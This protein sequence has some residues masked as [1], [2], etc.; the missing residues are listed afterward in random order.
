MRTR[1]CFWLLILL[2]FVVYGPA[3][4]MDYGFRD[5]YAYLREAREE[6]G[7]LVFFN[8]SQGRPLYGALIETSFGRLDSASDLEWFRLLT[9]VELALLAIVL[10]RHFEFSGWPQVDAAFA[11]FAIVML[12][13]AQVAAGWAIGWPWVASL[14]LSVAGFMAVDT[15][16]EKGGLKRTMG[17]VGGIFIYA[18]SAL[19]YQSNV[20]FAVVPL[21]ATM[22]PRLKLRSRAEL[23]RWFCMH[24]V[25]LFTALFLSYLLLKVLYSSGDFHES[26]R[27]QLERN[28]F[29]K[30]AWFIWQ[31]VP[32]ALALFLLRCDFN[33]GAVWF[34]LAAVAV[35]GF[36]GWILWIEPQKETDN[37][38]L[39]WQLCLG[40][41]P[42]VGHGVSLIAAERS[43]GY[44]TLFALSGLVVI[45]LFTALRRLPLGDK[46]RP[47]M[48]YAAMI[49]VALGAMYLAW[50]HTVKYIA[51]PQQK[52]WELVHEAVMNAHFQEK[53]RFYLIE[54]TLDDRSTQLVHRDEFGSL[55]TNSDWVP[56]EMFKT[57]L[58]ERFPKGLKAGRS[59]EFT[60]GLQPPAAG[61]YDILIDMRKIREARE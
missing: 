26:A 7:K 22:L 39:K 55:S 38:R 23:L 40:V 59:W 35:A 61:T 30:L 60:Q 58:H 57:A 33:T 49:V 6:P 3:V 8:T 54:P 10:W 36:I 31:P 2:P 37:E 24:L 32:N 13:A 51:E 29:T 16:L 52:E 11:A 28:P 42:F 19:I 15:E 41:L 21:A 44:R 43:T 20:M 17:V 27:V 56:K 4:L 48:Q 18:M 1:I 50:Y 34:W 53:T 25:I 45:V 46:L 14:L 5:D 47:Y 9:V 12:P